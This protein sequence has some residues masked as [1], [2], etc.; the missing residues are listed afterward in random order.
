MNSQLIR[1]A[2]KALKSG[3]IVVSTGAGVSAESGIPTFRGSADSLWQGY[4]PEDLATPEAFEKNP[5][6]V[7]DWYYWRRRLISQAQPNPGHLSLTELSLHRTDEFTLLTQN[8]DGLHQRAGYPN[9]IEMHGS[10]WNTK[11]RVCGCVSK[12]EALSSTTV[13]M[14]VACNSLTGPGVVWFGE[15]V[16]DGFFRVLSSITA[17]HTIMIVGTSGNVFPANQIA[18]VAKARGATTICVNVDPVMGPA[19]DIP[20]VG[21]SGDIL[22]LI[23]ENW[24]VV[25]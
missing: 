14:C 17:R 16:H 9:P 19:I 23:V 4:K 5:Q 22:P 18:T 12:D 13:P 11:C 3:P 15:E 2:I 6:L 25:V 1:D 8:V 24:G 20:L 7:W 10:I 21:K